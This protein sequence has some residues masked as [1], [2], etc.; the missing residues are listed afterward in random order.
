MK[1]I[2][3]L[4]ERDLTRIVRR[5]MN[6]GITF[7]KE[8]TPDEFVKYYA[9]SKGSYSIKDGKL[10]LIDPKNTSQENQITCNPQK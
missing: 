1:K 9:D 8:Y 7:I 3:K 6:E 4:T 2:V 5:V 10:I